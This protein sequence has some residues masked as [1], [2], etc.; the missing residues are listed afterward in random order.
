MFNHRL[1][2]FAKIASGAVLA[3]LLLIIAG[4]STPAQATG[5]T[6]PKHIIA[7]H[8]PI[9]LHTGSPTIQLALCTAPLQATITF[10]GLNGHIGGDWLEP[11]TR[12]CGTPGATLHLPAHS[13]HG[14]WLL[15]TGVIR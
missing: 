12:S 6:A 10:T 14:N 3:A 15:P 1:G 8:E 4:L 5:T 11:I 7:T 13:G 2:W 9:T